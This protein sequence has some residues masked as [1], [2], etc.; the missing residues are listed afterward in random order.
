[1]YLRE[2]RDTLVPDSDWLNSQGR[3]I[4]GPP[5]AQGCQDG[6]QSL[7][8]GSGYSTFTSLHVLFAYLASVMSVGE[9]AANC[10]IVLALVVSNAQCNGI[11]VVRY[12]SRPSYVLVL[13]TLLCLPASIC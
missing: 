11:L 10:N 8:D 3:C 13:K 6:P 1:M 9:G 12:L 5:G 7:A 2:R 4:Q